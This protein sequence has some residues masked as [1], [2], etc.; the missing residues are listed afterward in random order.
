MKRRIKCRNRSVN[1][2]IAF[3]IGWVSLAT[4][5]NFHIHPE[6]SAIEKIIFVKTEQKSLKQNAAFVYK[7]DLNAGLLRLLNSDDISIKTS[8]SFM[9]FQSSSSHSFK[10]YLRIPDLRGPPSI[11]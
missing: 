8:F 7:L 1:L 5:I 6:E 10:G 9:L 3:A 2:L 11:L 4:I